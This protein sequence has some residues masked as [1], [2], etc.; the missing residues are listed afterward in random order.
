MLYEAMQ[1]FHTK[2]C[3][4]YDINI[5]FLTQHIEMILFLSLKIKLCI[6]TFVTD[7]QSL[8]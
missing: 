3:Q 8:I 1:G 4:E 2:L 5:L 6:K 7:H